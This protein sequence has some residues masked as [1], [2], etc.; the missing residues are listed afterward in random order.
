MASTPSDESP[1]YAVR[2]AVAAG[3]ELRQEHSR[4]AGT[5]GLETA[6]SWRTGLM[7]KIRT[8]GTLPARCAAAPEDDYFADAV[9]HQLLYRYKRGPT[10]R[11]LFTVHEAD[12][13]DPPT[14]KV[15]HIRHGAQAAM[16]SWPDED[17]E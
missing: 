4:L 3:R 16:T 8:L 14:V 2:L 6:D 7:E 17:D 1:V 11:I 5:S 15:Q 13:N 9:I 12:E 10:W